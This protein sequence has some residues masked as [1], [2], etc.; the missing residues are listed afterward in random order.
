MKYEESVLRA[1]KERSSCRA[2]DGGALPDKVLS[3]ILEVGLHAASAG[4]LQAYTIVAVQNVEAKEALAAV[5]GQR[6]VA[7][8]AVNLVF[9][10]DWY[11]LECFARKEHAP[12]TVTRN[13]FHYSMAL[14]D[15]MCL[16]QSI[17]TAA[18]A[19]GVE[20]C[21]VGN[22]I[23]KHAVMQPLLQYP[24]GSYPMMML[25]LGYPKGELHQIKKLNS[26]VLIFQERYGPLSSEE[27]MEAYTYKYGAMRCPLP[28]EGEVRTAVLKKLG[29]A[30]RTTYSAHECEEILREVAAAGELNEMQRRFG[31][32]YHADDMLKFAENFRKELAE[33][34]VL[35]QNET[36]P[37]E[38]GSL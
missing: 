29:R 13:F 36:N 23:G 35:L 6:F 8:A 21:F 37:P 16:A 3:E 5:A 4:N 33:S 20:S 11:K 9:F 2:F 7:E 26:D 10:I 1:M 15:V 27:I 14:A 32:Q 22:I 12:I 17:E 38:T 28:A 25:S 24:P 34:G 31:V 18:R 19:L 30:L